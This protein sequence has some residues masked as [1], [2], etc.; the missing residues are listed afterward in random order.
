MAQLYEEGAV[1]LGGWLD[2]TGDVLLIMQAASA[3]EVLS[4]LPG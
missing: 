1:V 4:Q 2:D 3:S